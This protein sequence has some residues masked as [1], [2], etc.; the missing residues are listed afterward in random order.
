MRLCDINLNFTEHPN[1]LSGLK[2]LIRSYYKV[3]CWILNVGITVTVTVTLS[4]Q[5][6]MWCWSHSLVG[7]APT[8]CNTS[9]WV[10]QVQVT[11]S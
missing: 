5:T 8:S 7:S 6:P 2:S 10:T 11:D 4:K 9:L 3:G 1:L